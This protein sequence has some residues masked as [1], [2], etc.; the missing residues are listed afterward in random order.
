MQ[1]PKFP[2]VCVVGMH[3]RG[4]Y[5]KAAVE[6]MIPPVELTLEREPENQY[7][8]LAI[9]VMLNGQHIG[10]LERSQ[11]CFIAPWLDEGTE[12]KATVTRLEARK[13]N[14]HPI[15]DVTPV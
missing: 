15:V 7:D 6:S 9:K 4:D 8:Q 2:N 5:A 1:A 3:F 14:L 12:F 13:N 10:Y 11:S